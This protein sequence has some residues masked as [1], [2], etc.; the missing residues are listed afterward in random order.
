MAGMRWLK[1]GMF[2]SVV[3]FVAIYLLIYRKVVDDPNV[4]LMLGKMNVSSIGVFFSKIKNV[5]IA[6][7]IGGFLLGLLTGRG[8]RNRPQY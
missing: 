2:F 6:S 7:L 3:L 1:W 4:V 5:I 8:P